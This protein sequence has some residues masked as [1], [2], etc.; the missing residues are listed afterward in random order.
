MATARILAL[1]RPAAEMALVDLWFHV[2]LHRLMPPNLRVEFAGHDRISLVVT[3]SSLPLSDGVLRAWADRWRTQEYR[4]CPAC[5][6]SHGKERTH[7]DAVARRAADATPPA[8]TIRRVAQPP[9]AHA[10]PRRRLPQR[11]GGSR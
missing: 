7:R 5:G 1:S 8:R 3:E 4:T 9:G 2:A 6:C 10:A 11:W